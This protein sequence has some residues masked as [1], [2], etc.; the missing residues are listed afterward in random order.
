MSAILDLD[1]PPWAHSALHLLPAG[2][3]DWA[4]WARE[5]IAPGEPQQAPE[6]LAY[7]IGMRWAL[8]RGGDMP[9]WL[10]T[11]WKH[12]RPDSDVVETPYT[13]L[14]PA[15]APSPAYPIR[16]LGGLLGDAA[17]AIA[18]AAQIDPAIVGQSIL[19]A[20]SLACQH[21]ADVSTPGGNK[22]LSN[23]FLTIALSGDGKS[24]A[25]APALAPVREIERRDWQA[26][27]RERGEW[28][29][30]PKKGRG[31]KPINPLRLVGDF[32]AEGLVRQY[33]EGM[34][35]LGA[36][37][38]EAGAVF[39]G[40]SF[41]AEKKLATAAALSSLWDGHGI[42]ARARAADDRGG[43]EAHFDVRLTCHWLI[44]PAAVHASVHDNILAEQGFWPRTLL[45]TPAP[46][47]PRLFKP[48]DATTLP[49]VTRYWKRISYLL[50]TPYVAQLYR[51]VVSTTPAANARVGKFF[52]A[53]ERG[54]RN[55]D[56][57][58]APIRSW[59]ARGTEHLLRLAA[60]LSVI[61][62]GEE[63]DI[64]VMEV[65][66]A[67]ALVTYSLECWLYLLENKPVDEAREY[68]H[69]LLTW[70][71][72]QPN[73]QGNETAMIKIGPK[74]RSA[75]LRDAALGL[76]EAQGRVVGLGLRRWAVK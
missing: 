48:F 15:A 59:A 27:Q 70:L 1:L 45:A 33:R 26:Y 9:A 36:F 2:V 17:C 41:T 66:R 24:T 47:L 57:R 7:L 28:D 39:G 16:A 19:A 37:S 34:P 12:G 43:L 53:C 76:L 71:S 74:P 23:N 35:S 56:G 30:T 44:Q 8:E 46:G 65:E 14:L 69:R 22:P 72:T 58:L 61:E 54:A 25:D 18:D 29:A 52:E 75:S 40:H 73:G 62:R 11:L 64:D 38:D 20:A 6:K 13:P 67:A 51:P 60:V 10:D 4:H 55:N 32:T 21:V 68:A 63:A 3:A 5:V 50:G 49:E 42:R 31:D